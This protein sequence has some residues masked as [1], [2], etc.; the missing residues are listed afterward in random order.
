MD[1]KT[2]ADI[3]HQ[4][5]SPIIKQER[6]YRTHPDKLAPF[7]AEVEDLLNHDSRPMRSSKRWPGGTLRHSFPLG[8][9]P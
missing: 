6:A 8:N 7:W 9:E 1:R 4:S 5:A 3:L 2:A